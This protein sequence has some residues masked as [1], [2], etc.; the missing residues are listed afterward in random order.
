MNQHFITELKRRLQQPLPGEEIQFQMAPVKRERLS[1][2]PLSERNPRSSAVLILLYP[3]NNSIRT[4]LIERPVYEGVHSGQV[5]FPGGKFEPQ[6]KILENTALRE[7]EEEIGIKSSDVSV[8]GRLTDLYISPS[9]FL[10]SPIIGY[11]DHI[12]VFSP[13]P[14]EVNKVITIGLDLLN[15]ISIRGVKTITYSGGYK[16]KT[17]YYNVEGLTVWGAT[18]MII[19]ELNAVVADVN[20]IF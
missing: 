19:S 6:D 16:I 1:E 5:S 10:V 12:P 7:A 15:D 2:I 11:T 8:L 17:P 3:Y 13:D 18:A 20:A 14:R 9:N 4:V